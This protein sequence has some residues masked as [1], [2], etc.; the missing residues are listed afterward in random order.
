MSFKSVFRFAPNVRAN[1]TI[2][3]F[4]FSFSIRNT[5]FMYYCIIQHY[6]KNILYNSKALHRSKWF[7]SIGGDDVTTRAMPVKKQSIGQY[8]AHVST[9]L[10]INSRTCSCSHLNAKRVCV[11]M[12]GSGWNILYSPRIIT[13]FTFPPR[14][15][16]RAAISKI[17][18]GVIDKK[19]SIAVVMG[20]GAFRSL[21]SLSLSIHSGRRE[22]VGRIEKGSSKEAGGEPVV[23]D[24]C[25]QG[26][27]RNTRVLKWLENN[28]SRR[29]ADLMTRR[30]TQGEKKTPEMEKRSCNTLQNCIISG[31]AATFCA[32]AKLQTKFGDSIYRT[33]IICKTDLCLRFGSEDREKI[34]MT[35]KL[36]KL[37][38]LISVP[39]RGARPTLNTFSAY[40]DS[41]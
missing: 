10:T 39:R 34:F 33:D 28:G 25:M 7:L 15:A 2:F 19:P 17:K 16:E 14:R 30:W 36:E 38:A 35:K 31:S 8:L 9:L 6:I 4:L 23:T 12:S 11:S 26:G 37:F 27:M 20:E 3:L 24:I 40:R 32:S 1:P 22:R 18:D 5:M 41:V 29:V 13:L 21:R